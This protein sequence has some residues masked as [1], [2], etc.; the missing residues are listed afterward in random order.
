MGNERYER[1]ELE[2]INFLT[3]DVITTSKPEY[4]ESIISWSHTKIPTAD[5]FGARFLF[6]WK[7]NTRGCPIIQI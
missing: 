5:A 6:R 4:E 1:T 3:K 7:K 2:I